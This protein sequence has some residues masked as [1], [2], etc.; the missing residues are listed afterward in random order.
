MPNYDE[1]MSLKQ[2]FIEMAALNSVDNEKPAEL[3]FYS[4]MGAY[5]KNVKIAHGISKKDL[6]FS[7]T[8]LQTARTGKGRLNNT[9]IR[10]GN[11]IGVKCCLVTEYTTAG[12]IGTL[13]RDA[14][15][16]NEK[17]AP[18]G[19]SE[20]QPEI[21]VDIK[22][23]ERTIRWRDPIIKGDAGNYDIII[24][25][26]LKQLLLPSRENEQIML[27]LQPALDSPPHI[28]KKMSSRHPVEY[29][30]PLT[31]IGT[32]FPFKS[33]SKIVSTSGYLQRTYFFVRKLSDEEVEA[34]LVKQSEI[35]NKGIDEEFN[36]KLE[37]FKRK[38][39]S[40][41]RSEKVISVTEQAKKQL[42]ALIKEYIEKVKGT[43][44]SNKEALISF[45]NTISEAALK[46]ASIH[47]V[48]LGKS[49]VDSIHV[50]MSKEV[51]YDFMNNLIEKFDVT[52]DKD[53]SSLINS[54][55]NI[56]KRTVA[57]Q[58]KPKLNYIEFMMPVSRALNIGQNKAGKLIKELA[59][60]GYFIAERSE[61]NAL[62]FSLNER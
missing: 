31:I 15:L 30:N 46:I 41:D 62:I 53:R 14:I 35:M 45:A 3:Y 38:L 10:V 34:M 43:R 17:Y 36:K 6:R 1:V 21:I 47:A 4:L 55:I 18:Y 29:S 39:S 24:F 58:E 42:L 9:I 20:H 2:L 49:E 27:S 23:K 51:I 5:L 48:I 25:D 56:F 28:R 44:G 59:S 37:L 26:E 7:I 12:I 8:W 60:E 40:I 13:D 61:N 54:V 16:H 11:E 33:V 50:R 32:T 57:T 22:G 19:L 52:E